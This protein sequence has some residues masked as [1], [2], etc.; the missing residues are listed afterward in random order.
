M[1]DS[2]ALGQDPQYVPLPTGVILMR[3]SVGIVSLVVWVLS[4]GSAVGASLPP[5]LE[6]G[7]PGMLPVMND[8][9][10]QWKQVTKNS[11]QDRAL[12][13]GRV[14][15][16]LLERPGH[17]H[18]EISLDD[19]AGESI[20]VVYNTVFGELPKIVPGMQAAACG[21]YITTKGQKNTPL[22]AIVHWVHYNP[23][24]RDGGVHEHGYLVLDGVVYGNEHNEPSAKKGHS[25]MDLLAEGVPALVF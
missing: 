16:L 7:S 8:Q 20:E 3:R 21:D 24:D 22:G 17:T 9:V 11:Y 5:C 14:V 25:L 18:I 19:K 4:I 23:G 12:V 2:V 10:I 6:N 1:R 15:R 13:A